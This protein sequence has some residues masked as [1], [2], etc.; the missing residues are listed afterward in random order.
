MNHLDQEFVDQVKK[1]LE[2]KKERI[3]RELSDIT[4][5]NTFDGEKY[6]SRFPDR[7]DA[8]DE[9]AQEVAAYGDR[10]SLERTLKA[11]L[12]DVEKTLDIIASGKY[13]ICKHCGQ[14]IEKKRLLARPASSSCIDCKK[15]LKGED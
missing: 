9:N 10:L 11:S 14:D 4:D 13:G 15:R 3:L 6:Q 5:G 12:K 7:G 1:D 2:D 8:E